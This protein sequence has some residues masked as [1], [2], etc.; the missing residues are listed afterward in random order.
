[1]FLPHPKFSKTY[2]ASGRYII[3]TFESLD[4]CMDISDSQ[5][6]MSDGCMVHDLECPLV[7]EFLK[8]NATE[9]DLQ[10]AWGGGG[11]R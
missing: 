10:G 11:V 4:S 1:M 8:K 7:Q 9:W 3:R 2:N 5:W 6:G